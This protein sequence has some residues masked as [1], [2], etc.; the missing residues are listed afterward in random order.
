MANMSLPRATPESQGVS[1][2][3]LLGFIKACEKKIDALHSMMLLRHGKVVAE[4]WWAPY[5]AHLPHIL[6]SLSKSFTSTAVGLAAAEGRLTVDDLVISFFPDDLPKK[7]DPNL[8]KMRIRHLLSMSTGHAEDTTGRMIEGGGD[9]FVRGF[10]ALPVENEPGAPFVYNSGASYMLS[11]I[12]Q[13]VTGKTLLEYL[14][15]RLFE[16]LGIEGATWES[17]PRG[18]NM[19][20]WGLNI[21]TEDIA[22]FG[23]LYLQKGVWNGKRILPEAWVQEATRKQ[24]SNGDPSTPNDWAQG[25]GYQFWRCRHGAYRGDGAFGQYCIVMPA[26]DAVLA[27]TSGVPDMQAVMNLVWEHILLP[28]GDSPLPEDPAAQKKL[29]RKLASLALRLPKGSPSSPL[30]ASLNGKKYVFEPNESKVQS[31][32]LD[33]ERGCAEVEAEGGKFE[34]TWGYGAWR[35]G[36]VPWDRGE[37]MPAASAGAWKD[38]RTF[39]LL[40]RLYTTPFYQTHTFEFD[41]DRLTL[42]QRINVSFGPLE[43]APLLGRAV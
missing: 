5:A 36:A 3:A 24:V 14:T 33:F 38:E 9:N 10:L 18:I 39:V 7:V 29:A 19:G 34:L 22:R 11:A 43:R 15:P 21:R 31:L 25:Y 2:T 35:N 8:A 12:V 41:G 28:M 32:V 23:Q 16:P 4:G 20:G 13:K 37:S 26:Q 42:N 1:S 6:F 40:Q 30:A 17:C 27:I